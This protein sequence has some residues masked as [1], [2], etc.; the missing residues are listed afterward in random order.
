[1][2]EKYQNFLDKELRDLQFGNQQQDHGR[3]F[4]KIEKPSKYNIKTVISVVNQ[5]GGCGK[6][7]TAINLSACLAASEF[8]V[9]LIDAD[10]QA[11]ASLGL[12]VDI[13]S[14][15]KT[16]YAVMTESVN[17]SS[18]ILPTRI[19]NL[20]IVPSNA[21]LSGATLKLG[22]L[23]SRETILQTAIKE[24]LFKNIYD[25]IIIDCSP[26]L[27]LITINALVASHYTVIPFQTHYYSME[28]MK[29]LFDT[30]DIIQKQFNPDLRTLGIL[31]TLFDKRNN[32]DIEML[33]QVRE[34]F[35]DLVFETVIRMNV[36]LSEAPI[37]NKPIHEYCEDS[38][39]AKDYWAL[40]REVVSRIKANSPIMKEN[41]Y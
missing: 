31:G 29:D 9:L 1:M 3:D 36:K 16:L 28:G 27:N 19:P 5:K 12:G 7:T 20:D 25:Y 4:F 26:S 13:D 23:L 33:R 8:R 38:H 37:Y 24:F 30:I 10:S 2:Y 41:F 14:P 39:G 35:K 32:T 21:R 11:Q 6:T 22:Y 18:A 40:S 34:S 15:E 17:I